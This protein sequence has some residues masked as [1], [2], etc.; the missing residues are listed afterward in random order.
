[1]KNLI[2]KMFGTKHERDVKKMQPLVAEIN[3]HF[4]RLKSL[5]D[6]ELQA[7]TDEFKTRLAK[8]ETVDD[9][10]TEAF[11]VVKETCHRHLGQTWDVVNQPTEWNMVP[12]DVQLIGAVALHQG[13]IA[14]MSTGEGK[15]LVATMPT[16]LNALT[17]KGVHIVTVNDYLARRDL[18][19]MGKIYEFL[20]LTIGVIQNQMTNE[21]R[22]EK[23]KCDITFGTAN[24]FGFD[25]LRDNMAQR[26]EDRVHRNRYYA[27]ID[28][29]DS[30]LIDEARTPLIISGQV[31]SKGHDRYREMKPTVDVLVRKQTVLVNDMIA[32]AEKL[33]ASGNA[34]DE[35]EAGTLLLA[36]TRGAP[37]NKRL[38][39][40][41][42]ETGMKKL[43]TDV[44]SAFMRDKKLHEVD[45]RLYFFIDEREHS[46]AL[47]DQGTSQLSPEEQKLFE[48]P[49]ISIMLS[50]LEGDES[51]SPEERQKKTD[52]IYRVHGELSEKVHAINQL[53]RAWALYEKDVEYVLQDGKVMIVDEF[54]GR[55]LPGRR[56]SDGLHQA[57]EAKEGVTIE[58][59]SQ[60][61]ATITLQNYFR[62]YD[63]LAG[64]TGTAETEAG[65]FWDI[66]KLDV[67]V[68]PT[69]E[70]CIRADNEDQIY[71]TRRE[72]YKA[73]INEITEKYNKGQPILVGTVSVEVSETLSRMLKRSG[74]PHN[75]LNAKQHQRE[76]EI[77]TRA[78]EQGSI[79]IATNM[80]GRGTDIR[81]GD[82]VIERGG[83]HIIGTERHDARRIDRQLRGR[84][85]RQGDPGSSI[86]YLSLE[87]D[88]MRL[89]GGDRL[90]SVMDRLG[91]KDDEVITHK[92]VTKAIERAQKKV[93][94]QNFSIRKHTLDYDD[95]MNV[96]RNWIYERRLAALERESIKDEVV[97]LIE[98]VLEGLIDD[99]CPEKVYPENWNLTGF[100]DELRK[101]YLLNLQFK[102][103]DIP[104]LTREKLKEQVHGA[105]MHIYNQ[106]EAAYGEEIM[107]QL[108]R[109]AVLSTIDRHWR[110][111]LA[112]MD[113]LRT[114]IGLRAYHGAM[115]KPIDIYKREAFRMLEEMST[116]VDREIVNLVYKL[117]V[118]LPEKSRAERRRMPEAVAS[119]ADTTGMGYASAVQAP[120]GAE[121]EKNPMAEA[122]QAGRQQRTFRR[123]VPKVG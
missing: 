62:M 92:M 15:T 93:E 102:E 106:K 4:E 87:D 32:K 94:A 36:A 74:I 56:Y 69:N 20:G 71:R 42:K 67:A 50:E 52:E 82:G 54:T 53:L 33:L 24:E 116:T 13:K 21:E 64:M 11:A 112:E 97:E 44:E 122:S 25:Y 107:R 115:G 117:Q 65:E 111:H 83:L 47:T 119:H 60:T 104:S 123:K 27:I 63:K 114:G 58:A 103:E 1:M 90:G 66:Y 78:G 9:I 100:T 35:F 79:T 70:P 118:S 3:D 110:D 46:I 88:L 55:I 84:S 109:Y 23:Y 81:L 72:K 77:V 30:I 120:T 85:G 16:Y 96:Q 7:K 68:I 8:R 38:L 48:I 39:K 14:E 6:E 22:R 28:E 51:L 99:H 89:F 34:D 43:V 49:D 40:V 108:E 95:V 98:E 91:V 12:F 86:F 113:E 73:I 2:E 5:S 10:M 31:D 18:E 19:W 75:V 45:D 29:V 80:A 37:K 57:I 17:G 76:A 26:A 101:I 61:L 59:E 41:L 121:T 105:V